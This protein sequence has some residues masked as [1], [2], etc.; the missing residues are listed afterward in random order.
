MPCKHTPGPWMAPDPS[1]DSQ[2]CI[3]TEA[4]LLTIATVA[5]YRP[6]WKANARLIAAAPELLS[7]LKRYV[8]NDTGATDIDGLNK[9][10]RAA[11]AKAEPE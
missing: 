11:I 6:E 3:F 7:A 2:G 9:D 8:E 5:T 1:E 4:T 10:A